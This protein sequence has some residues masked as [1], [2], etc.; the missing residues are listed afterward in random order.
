MGS[1]PPVR[2]RQQRKAIGNTSFNCGQAALRIGRNN[3]LA[4][5]HANAPQQ[6]FFHRPSNDRQLY[7]G[8]VRRICIPSELEEIICMYQQALLDVK[9]QLGKG[10]ALCS[11]GRGLHSRRDTI[12]PPCFPRPR[13][14]ANRP[15]AD[16]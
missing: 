16:L 9:Q 11:L 3:H 15:A 4:F 10:N 7:A 5:W 2:R 8:A 14:R 13:A 12:K 1:H 6:H